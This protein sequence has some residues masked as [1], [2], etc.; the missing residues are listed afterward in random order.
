MRKWLHRVDITAVQA[1]EY[2]GFRS[3]SEYQKANPRVPLFAFLG[4][5]LEAKREGMLQASPETLS[6]PAWNC[7]G[8]AISMQS[9]PA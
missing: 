7:T 6:V 3:L 2:L 9:M 5:M 1:C 8:T 4:M